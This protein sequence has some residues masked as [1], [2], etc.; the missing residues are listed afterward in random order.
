MQYR[1]PSNDPT[2]ARQNLLVVGPITARCL[3]KRTAG[4]PIYGFEI[5]GS[6]DDRHVLKITG[7]D[8]EKFLLEKF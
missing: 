1:L 8:F 4:N 7:G 5:L 2:G 3:K 6:D